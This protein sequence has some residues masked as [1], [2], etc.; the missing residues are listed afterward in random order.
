MG[1]IGRRI[2]TA[3]GHL[4]NRDYE[5]ALIQVCIAIDGTAKKKWQSYKPGK[6]I[7]T[8]IDEYEAFIYQ[9][10]SSGYLKLRGPG[11]QKGKIFINGS[12]SDTLYKSIR[13]VLHHGDEIANHIELREGNNIIGVSRG[14]FILNTGYID[15]FMFSVIADKVNQ[16]EFCATNPN[17]YH[18]GIQIRINDLW[19]NLQTIEQI[20]GYKKVL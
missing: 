12:L 11:N 18:N 19:G 2:D 7:R 14:K 16:N 5:N 13:C 3:I 10:A 9:F 4:T 17:Y 1:T 8:F 6:R 15:G 20:I